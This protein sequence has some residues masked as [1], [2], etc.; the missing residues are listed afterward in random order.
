MCSIASASFLEKQL[1]QHEAFICAGFSPGNIHLFNLDNLS[2][3]FLTRYPNPSEKNKYGYFSF[4]PFVLSKYL[5]VIPDNDVLLYLDV[6]DK[7][8]PGLCEYLA[9]K[10][11]FDNHINILS[12]GTN[13]RNSK[14]LSIYHRN[15]LSTELLLASAL[16]FQPE[17]GLVAIRNT[18]DSKSLLAIWYELTALNAINLVEDLDNN[19]RHDQETLFLLSRLN[20]SVC[21]ESWWRNKIFKNGVRQYIDWE[22]YRSV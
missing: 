9:N 19:S 15:M 17:A 20:K 12:A 13:Y 6:N 4:K 18:M 21:V 5:D 10:F 22:C 7:P 3:S 11:D 16:Y 8:L 14:H 2:A 1:L